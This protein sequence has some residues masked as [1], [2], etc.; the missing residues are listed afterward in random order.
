M[1]HIAFALVLVLALTP[2]SASAQRV[3]ERRGFWLAGAISGSSVGI[4]CQ[5]DDCPNERKTG[6]SG[7]VQL[8]GT[9]SRRTLVGVEVNGWRNSESGARREYIAVMGI[10]Y[11]YPSADY[12]FF[13]KFGI[14]AGRYGAE[15]TSDVSSTGFAV[16]IGTGYDIA[17]G[18]R[19][20][21]APVIQYISAPDQ[22]AKLDRFPVSSDFSLNL[23]QAGVKVSWH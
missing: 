21:I 10:G 3:D 11:L 22:N 13:L 4:D 9:L 14:G 19:V 2:R 16:Q 23:I 8:G 12:P 6:I 18:R 1:R 20:W 7:F 17:I 5:I 15:V